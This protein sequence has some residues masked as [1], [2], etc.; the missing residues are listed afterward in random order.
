MQ[1]SG[2]WEDVF[3]PQVQVVAYLHRWV[4]SSGGVGN[5]AGD[6][7]GGEAG[8]AADTDQGGGG[9]DVDNDEHGSFI[10]WKDKGQVTPHK[11]L[12]YPLAGS[13]VDGSTVVHAAS[14][15]RM[16]DKSL[17]YIDK[18]RG[19]RLRW[20]GASEGT[21]KSNSKSESNSKKGGFSRDEGEWT[22]SRDEEEGAPASPPLQTYAMDDLRISI[23]YRARCFVDASD[24]VKFREQLHGDDGTGGRMPLDGV[25]RRCVSCVVCRVSCVVCSI[26]SV[27]VLK[28]CLLCVRVSCTVY[29]VD[30]GC[31][32]LGA[33]RSVLNG[34]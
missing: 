11:V 25:L 3:V 13:A 2:L 9:G 24:A 27:I 19:H 22:L 5:G 14:T 15:Y 1:F 7:A 16:D 34:L 29:S 33:P 17:P 23:V 30:G 20:K 21:S 18:S 4:P 12:P 10:Y 8:E 32:R 31:R 26:C 28:Y 6:G